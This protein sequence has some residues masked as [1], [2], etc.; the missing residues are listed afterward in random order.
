MTGALNVGFDPIE[1]GN[2]VKF[3]NETVLWRGVSGS[4]TLLEGCIGRWL[5][6]L[7]ASW[8][9]VKGIGAVTYRNVDI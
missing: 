8:L 5:H 2:K 3:V 7:M 9:V 6:T 1:G 4:P